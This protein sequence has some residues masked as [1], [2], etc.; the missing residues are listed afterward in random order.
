M[1]NTLLDILY[2]KLNTSVNMA[3]KDYYLHYLNMVPSNLK[4]KYFLNGDIYQGMKS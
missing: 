2:D 1:W 3:C 4:S